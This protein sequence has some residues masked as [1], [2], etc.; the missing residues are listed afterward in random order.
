MNWRQ[1]KSRTPPARQGDKWI[2]IWGD[3]WIGDSRRAGHHQPDWETNESLYGETNELETAEEPDTTSQTGRQMN[4]YMGKQVNWRQPKSRTPPAR[5]GDKWIV[6]WGNKWIGDSRR[7]G[8]HQPDWETNESLHGETNE[9]ETARLG[10]KWIVIW[11]DNWIGDSRRAG[12]HQ[13][14]WHTNGLLQGGT[15]ELET[16]EEPDTT[17]HTGRQMNRYIGKQMNWRQPKSRTPP[18]R[19]GD[20]WIVIWGDKWIRDM[21]RAGHHHL[22]QAGHLFKRELRT[23][24]VNCLGNKIQVPNCISYNIFPRFKIEIL[25]HDL[26]VLYA[27]VPSVVGIS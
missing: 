19:L 13:P 20:K 17:S 16:A 22:H 5:L 4:R 27:L 3:K 1:P 14:D 24:T 8:H 26:S 11:G 7:A 9:L 2:V 18:A 15:N 10:D 6:I 25:M 21:G 23:P 12:H